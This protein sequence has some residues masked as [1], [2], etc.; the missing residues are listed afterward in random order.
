MFIGINKF[1]CLSVGRAGCLSGCLS[2]WDQIFDLQ[3]C[4]KDKNCIAI[5]R[6]CLTTEM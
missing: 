3:K 5:A 6:T 2:V 4:Y 1:V